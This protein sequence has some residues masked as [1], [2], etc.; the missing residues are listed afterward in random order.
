VR[1]GKERIEENKSAIERE[2]IAAAA[3]EAPSSPAG[4]ELETNNASSVN[5]SEKSEKQ[6]SNVPTDSTVNN[7]KSSKYKF[8]EIGS[9]AVRDESVSHLDSEQEQDEPRSKHDELDEILNRTS[10]HALFD[11]TSSQSDGDYNA[12]SHT[13][14]IVSI[15]VDESLYD[16]DTPAANPSPVRVNRVS[17]DTSFSDN[18]ATVNRPPTTDVA[19]PSLSDH[20]FS[21]NDDKPSQSAS[22]PHGDDAQLDDLLNEMDEFASMNKTY[23]NDSA[24]EDTTIPENAATALTK[25]L[26]MNRYSTSTP[27][28]CSIVHLGTEQTE[29]SGDKRCTN[30]H[31]INC[32]WHVTAFDN[33][34]WVCMSSTDDNQNYLFLRNN[35]PETVHERLEPQQGWTAYCCQCTWDNVNSQKRPKT[36]KWICS[37]HNRDL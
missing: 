23:A 29:K 24:N 22:Q 32:D 34:K 26:S 30:I 35:Y 28:K 33:Q 18:N 8:P 5:E 7:T 37:G 25:R 16:F 19:L 13:S 9:P 14:S 17:P 21:P 12:A 27:G 4:T 1:S 3:V 15:H 36:R 6:Q 2:D 31:C 10:T 20:V 11:H